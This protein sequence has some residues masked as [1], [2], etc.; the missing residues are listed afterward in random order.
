MTASGL[1]CQRWDSQSP[2]SH[3][4]SDASRFPDAT[5]GETTNYCR[6][7]DNDATLWCYTTTSVRWDYC[8]VPMCESRWEKRFNMSCIPIGLF[9]GPITRYVRRECL[10]R[11]PCCRLQMKPLVSDPGMHHGTCVT[12]VPGIPGACTTRNC[13]VAGKRSMS[14]NNDKVV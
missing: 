4:N 13:C 8:A 9:H 11:F 14:M 1:P 6:N 5:M 10:E 12:D 2:H 3:P 7:P